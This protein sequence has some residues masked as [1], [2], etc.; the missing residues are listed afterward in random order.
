MQL[1]DELERGAH[2][3]GRVGPPGARQEAAN[4]LAWI[5]RATFDGQTSAAQDVGG[6]SGGLLGRQAGQGSRKLGG[7]RGQAIACAAQ[8][9]DHP[10]D[11]GGRVEPTASDGLHAVEDEAL[12]V[13]GH[14]Q[15][16]QQLK[17]RAKVA[18]DQSVRA[19][20]NSLEAGAGEVQD[21][22]VGGGAGRADQLEADL[23]ELSRA[24]A[25]RSLVA[26]AR[27]S[28]VQA[29]RQTARPASR[30]RRSA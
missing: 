13:L 6:D 1:G 21:L 15:L 14:A 22:G 10:L 8:E 16:S 30:R 19:D 23:G 7:V 28:V 4:D 2:L 12:R 25:R 29:Q 11:G 26:K 27:P 3:V 5:A 20:A 24:P 18:D 9:L 17:H